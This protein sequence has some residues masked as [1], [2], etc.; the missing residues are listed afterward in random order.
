MPANRNRPDARMNKTKAGQE[1][2]DRMSLREIVFIIQ[3]ECYKT[4]EDRAQKHWRKKPDKPVLKEG[5]R[6]RGT[7]EGITDDKTRN[8]EKELNPIGPVGE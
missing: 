6:T 5:S 2:E 8:N 3:A 1:I 7:L 4:S